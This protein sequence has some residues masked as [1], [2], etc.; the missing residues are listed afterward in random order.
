M[1]RDFSWVRALVLTAALG[2]ARLAAAQVVISE[3]WVRGTVEGQTSTV[4]YMTLKSGVA[5][6]LVSVTSPLAAR[7]TVHEMTMDGNLMRMRALDALQIPA[8]ATVRLEEGHD[9][10]MLEGLKRP[11]K[12]GETVSL[13]LQFVDSKGARQTVKV[14]APVR[15]LGA[16]SDQPQPND[17]VK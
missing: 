15:A 13:T 1:N 9:H 6:R 4:A 8:G 12:A 16:I 10:L 14:Q 5:T 17:P 3:P 7:C 2:S 11:I